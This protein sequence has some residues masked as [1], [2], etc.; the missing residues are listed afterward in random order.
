MS[1]PRERPIDSYLQSEVMT[2]GQPGR[3]KNREKS[4]RWHVR[5]REIA[6][7]AAHLF[8]KKGYA[9]AGISDLSEATGLGKGA[10]YYYI[11]SKEH[12][13]VEIHDLVLTPLIQVANEIADSDDPPKAKLR[14]MTDALLESITT[15]IDHVWVFLHEWKSLRGKNAKVFREKRR[16][17][18]DA[19]ESI[20]VEGM[21]AGDFEVSDIR[22]TS[23]AWFGMVNYTYQWYQPEGRLPP[24]KIAEE[25]HQIFTQGILTPKARKHS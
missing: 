23:L 10:L 19:L 20:L 15:H 14:R 25:Y 7:I 13:L 6:D 16:I 8:A 4:E 1:L 11:I 12:L 18:E 9:G 3:K 5:R 2:V 24:E 22:L 17:V 21:E